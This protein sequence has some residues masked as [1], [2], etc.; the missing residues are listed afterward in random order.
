MMLHNKPVL[1]T[2][3]TGFIGSH[4]AWRLAT[5]SG[6]IVTGTGR[7][8]AAVPFLAEAGVTLRHADLLDREAMAA[9]LAGQEIV[10]HVAAWLSER[11]GTEAQ[12]TRYNV[13]ATRLL[14]EMAHAAG[15]QR[16]VCVSSIAAYGPPRVR[17]MDEATQSAD[18]HQPEIYGKTKAAGEIAALELGQRLGIAV[19]VARPGMVYGPRSY[20]WTSEMVRL[21]RR[22]VPVLFGKAQGHAFPVYIDNLVDGLL[23]LATRPEAVG[24]PFNF[25]DAPVTWEQFFGRYG[26]MAG[27]KPRRVPYPLALALVA[28]NRLFRLGLPLTRQRLRFYQTQTVYPTQKAQ[29]LLG[30]RP[31][32]SFDEG[33]RR[34]EQWLREEK[35]IP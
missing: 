1:V 32:I 26:Q 31:N 19:T 22:G 2:G 21:I 29:R 27:R 4:L 8:L 16:V 30:Y 35:L 14:V 34:S 7:N 13:E 23:L 17:L 6:A 15:V 25:V 20:A 3:A 12:A 24:Q 11:H 28:A 33:M 5:E 10:F 18:P 9:A